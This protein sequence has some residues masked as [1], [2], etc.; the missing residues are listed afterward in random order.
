MFRSISQSRLRACVATL[1]LV[2]PGASPA[3]AQGDPAEA[4]AAA[5]VLDPLSVEGSYT[6]APT[7]QVKDL[8]SGT[9]T[10]TPRLSLPQQVDVVTRQRHSSE[11]ESI[12]ERTPST[13]GGASSA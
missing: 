11:A 5:V 6:A 1:A 12:K 8:Y 10:V 4:A 3:L 13:V 2:L 9:K 7:Y